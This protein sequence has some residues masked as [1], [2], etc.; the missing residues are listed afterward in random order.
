MNWCGLPCY[1]AHLDT[2][3]R[4]PRYPALDPIPREETSQLKPWRLKGDC[5]FKHDMSVMEPI[6]NIRN[7]HYLENGVHVTKF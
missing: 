1:P 7:E 4:V 3:F 2:S 5:K 6:F